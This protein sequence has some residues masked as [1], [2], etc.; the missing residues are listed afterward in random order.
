MQFEEGKIKITIIGLGYV[1][2]PLAVEFSKKFSVIGFDINVNR[3]VE[4]SEGYDRTQEIDSKSLL[5]TK[6]LHFTTNPS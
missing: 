5:A 1:G 3:I 4:L 6:F 2:L